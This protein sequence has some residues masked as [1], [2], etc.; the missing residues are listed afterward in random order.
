VKAIRGLTR[1]MSNSRF[2]VVPQFVVRSALQACSDNLKIHIWRNVYRDK[3]WDMALFRRTPQR[4]HLRSQ[5]SSAFCKRLIVSG[6]VIKDHSNGR[7][8]I[9][10]S[11][12]DVAQQLSLIWLCDNNVIVTYSKYEERNIVDPILIGPERQSP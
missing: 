9:F 12:A 2:F 7:M 10:L 1:F 5:L 4:F 11:E 8:S 3:T 6:A